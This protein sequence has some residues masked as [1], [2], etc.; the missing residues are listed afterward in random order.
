MKKFDSESEIIENHLAT[1]DFQF[2][3]YKTPYYVYF[4]RI[5]KKKIE[6][7]HKH[8][9]DAFKIYYSIKANP[10]TDLLAY[11]CPLVDG[12]EV[13]SPREMKL[14]LDIGMA[15]ENLLYTGPGKTEDE[16][17]QAVKFGVVI[18]AES[19]SEIARIIRLK[20]RLKGAKLRV[21]LRVNPNFIQRHAGMKMACGS[22]PFGMDEELVPKTV[23]IMQESNLPVYGFHVYTGSQ[24]LDADAINAAQDYIFQLFNK[25]ESHC[26]KP[27]R[28]L[29]LGGGFGIPYFIGHQPLD[30]RSVCTNLNHLWKGADTPLILELGRYIIGEAGIYVCQ[31]VDRKISKGKVYLITD[32]GM[33]HHLAASGNLGQKVRKNFPVYVPGNMQSDQKET[34]T[35]TGKLCTPLDVLAED[36]ELPKCETG[37]YIAIMNSGAYG[38]TASPVN[39]LSHPLANE[40]LA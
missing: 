32:G 18:S 23:G 37:D 39:F 19:E 9:N 12:L 35:V 17:E 33:H 36:I 29:N 27:V 30:I 10:F 7:L 5:I 24:I 2:N 22:S 20:H 1:S 21:M 3:R 8:L 38:L 34:V 26:T 16:L 40:I 6:T 13:S 15:S 11:L 14:A 4:R 31:V 25:L 28:V